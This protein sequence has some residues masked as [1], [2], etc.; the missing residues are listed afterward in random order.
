MT[1]HVLLLL[2]CAVVLAAC[3]H[4]PTSSSQY[5]LS[6]EYLGKRVFGPERIRMEDKSIALG[7]TCEAPARGER[8]LNLMLSEPIDGYFY[9]ACYTS[10]F[11][12]VG[13][14]RMGEIAP[15]QSAVLECMEQ[16]LRVVLHEG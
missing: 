5:T 4:S 10:C 6:V 2:I 1:R 7:G 3:S 11:F 15:G 12:G 14:G 8:V 9:Y 13:E 16:D